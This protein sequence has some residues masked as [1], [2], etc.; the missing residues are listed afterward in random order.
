MDA[1]TDYNDTPDTPARE[2]AAWLDAQARM[3]A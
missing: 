3:K 1:L 2:W